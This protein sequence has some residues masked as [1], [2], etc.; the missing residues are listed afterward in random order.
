MLTVSQE[1]YEYWLKL[2]RERPV[3][4][5]N[6]VEPGAIRGIL[7]D[8]FILDIGGASG[9]RFRI[10]GS[11]ANALFLRE[12]R[13]SSFLHLWRLSDRAPVEA[14]LQHAADLARPRALH[15]EARPTG[16]ANLAI[17]MILLPL[18]HRGPGCS[19]MLGAVAVE[20]L[21]PWHGLIGAGEIALTSDCPPD[22]APGAAD[23]SSDS[24][25]LAS[26]SATHIGRHWVTR[27]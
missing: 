1:L 24:G 19:R 4:D 16:L 18:R 20:T 14:I 27:P 21:P 17:E 7:A 3:P 5:R 22:T 2:K 8:T 13:G 10:S 15:A 6:E 11:R 23:S 26:P 9:L 25:G 12:L